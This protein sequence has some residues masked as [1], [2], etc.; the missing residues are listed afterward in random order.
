MGISFSLLPDEY[1]FSTSIF[2]YPEALV[3]TIQTFGTYV[4]NI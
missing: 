3:H 4:P 1:I 2:L